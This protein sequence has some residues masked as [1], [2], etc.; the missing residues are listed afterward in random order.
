MKAALPPLLGMASLLAGCIHDP[1]PGLFQ[2]KADARALECVRVTQAEAHALHPEAVSAPNP[3]TANL[4]N[5]DAILCQPRMMRQDE[6]PAR[7]DLILSSLRSEVGQIDS[8]V[9]TRG[10]VTWH[11][12]AFY[13]RQEVASK[14]ALAAK[15]DLAERGQRVSDRPPVL[16]AADLS[17]LGTLSPRQAFPLACTRYFA[18]GGLTDQD[19]FLALMIID[20]REAVLHAG[21]CLR[22]TWRW[23]Q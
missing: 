16:A 10:D 7:D 18:E 13:P 21:V 22:G 11:V 8:I 19:G 6:R 17:V 9:A 20:P 23:L 3:R 12:D 1:A 5:T 14:I 2:S 15:T 4:E